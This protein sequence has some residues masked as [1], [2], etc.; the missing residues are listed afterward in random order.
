M[1]KEYEKH[2]KRCK[3]YKRNKGYISSK[4]RAEAIKLILRKHKKEFDKL[5]EN[6]KK[7]MEGLNTT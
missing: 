6:L 7:E 3:E 5:V 2:K 1:D 4:A